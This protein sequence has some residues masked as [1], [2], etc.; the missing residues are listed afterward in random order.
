MKEPY[1]TTYTKKY[2]DMEEWHL[3]SSL[4]F[5]TV[6]QHSISFLLDYTKLI[7]VWFVKG[8]LRKQ[9]CEG[10]NAVFIFEKRQNRLCHAEPVL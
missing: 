5:Y 6:K 9:C 3:K 7:G 2:R 8:L 1:A 10:G 4:F